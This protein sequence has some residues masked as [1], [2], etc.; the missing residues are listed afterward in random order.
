DFAVGSSPISVAVADVNG[1]GTPDLVVTNENSNRVT[2]LLGNRNAA[3]HFELT[4]SARTTA[5]IAFP[6]TVRALTPTN[7]VDWP[8]GGTVQDAFNNTA[9]GYLGTLDFTLSPGGD[10]GNYTFTAADQGRH[11]LAGL[12]LDAG[13][14]MLAGSDVANPAVG[15]SVTFTVRPAGAPPPGRS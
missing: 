12:V 7:Q 4:A 8:Y 6:L 14:Y 3:T 9:T 11:T 1:D 5:G 10:L 13:D 2:V 15:G